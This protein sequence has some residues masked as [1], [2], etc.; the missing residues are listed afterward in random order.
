[1]SDDKSIKPGVVSQLPGDIMSPLPTD[2]QEPLVSPEAKKVIHDKGEPF[3]FAKELQDRMPG[4]PRVVR[5]RKES[6]LSKKAPDHTTIG[7]MSAYEANIPEW[8]KRFDWCRERGVI[9]VRR[10]H[11]EMVGHREY[12]PLETWAEYEG[13]AIRFFHLHWKIKNPENYQFRVV[14]A[15]PSRRGPADRTSQ[16]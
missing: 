2:D 3:P 12:A 4:K 1:M 11:V 8:V 15:P 5:A 6:P 16:G 7:Y 9:L 13:D 14:E 10:Y